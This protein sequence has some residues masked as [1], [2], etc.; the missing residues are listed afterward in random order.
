MMYNNLLKAYKIYF[1]FD[2][3]VTQNFSVSFSEA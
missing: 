1:F 2:V 3:A